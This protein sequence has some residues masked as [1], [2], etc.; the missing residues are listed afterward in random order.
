MQPM[1]LGRSFVFVGKD[2]PAKILSSTTR[3]LAGSN[4]MPWRH[5][6]SRCEQIDAGERHTGEPASGIQSA[7]QPDHGDFAATAGQSQRSADESITYIEWRIAY[8][9]VRVW[10]IAAK[11]IDAAIEAPVT[12]VDYVGGVSGITSATCGFSN[13]ADTAS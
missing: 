8:Y 12:S 7:H 11:E 13:S 1:Q 10:A 2:Q 9:V 3:L 5:R 6:W 4:D